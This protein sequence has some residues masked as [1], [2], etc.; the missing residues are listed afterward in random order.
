[1]TKSVLDAFNTEA[2]KLAAMGVT[3]LVSSGDDGVAGDFCSD[4]KP[5][6][7]S[8]PMN[9]P[10]T[11]DSSSS[12]YLW[13]GDGTWTGKGYFPSFPATSPYVVAVG[14]TM[15]PETDGPEVACTSNGGGVITTG[16]GFSSYY[17]TPS[18]QT[19]AVTD[20][21]KHF[22]NTNSPSP[23]FNSKGRGLPDVA[24]IGVYYQTVIQK[25]VESLFGTSASTPVFA[26]L[27]SLVNAERL[28]NGQSSVGWINPTLYGATAAA[29][30]TDVT[31]GSIKCCSDASDPPNPICCNSGFSATAGW[32][33]VSGWGSITYP[34]LLEL[35]G[36]GVPPTA[37]PTTSQVPS[38]VPTVSPT[39]TSKPT[40]AAPSTGSRSPYLM[41]IS[42]PSTAPTVITGSPTSAKPSTSP[43]VRSTSRPSQLRTIA[44]SAEGQQSV[45]PSRPTLMPTLRKKLPS[46]V[47]TS[48]QV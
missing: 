44:P 15:G 34:K 21:F 46:G 22:D 11:A 38:V 31:E 7:K 6:K 3:V 30:Y 25:V 26:A 33:P 24:L 36:G 40:T 42:A 43:S 8:T 18:W 4:C 29:S 16:G 27:I 2:V 32:D 5:N 10:C 20:Y 28:R 37:A 35:L 19:S 45:A 17:A 14:A 13:K 12:Q 39:K 47:Y 48:G 23:G 1:M 9:C 41:P